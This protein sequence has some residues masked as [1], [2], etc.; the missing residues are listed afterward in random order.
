MPTGPTTCIHALAATSLPSRA[1]AQQQQKV[2]TLPHT[3]DVHPTT[4]PRYTCPCEF[5]NMPLYTRARASVAPN[6]VCLVLLCTPARTRVGHQRPCPPH[7]RVAPRL[8]CAPPAS[9]PPGSPGCSTTPRRTV[10]TPAAAATTA[11]QRRP[12]YNA[13]CRALFTGT[14]RQARTGQPRR[15]TRW[16]SSLTGAVGNGKDRMAIPPGMQHNTKSH[17]TPS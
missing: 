14:R 7:Q 4:I 9:V 17:A 2:D 13:H 8:P 12:T 15:N 5:L 11:K 10:H 16:H 3:P 1:I 6:G